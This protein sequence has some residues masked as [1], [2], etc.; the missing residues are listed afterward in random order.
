MLHN[1]SAL[2]SARGDVLF[3]INRKSSYKE[4]HLAII[5][6]ADDVLHNYLEVFTFACAVALICN[7]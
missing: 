3:T 2:Q 4:L 7:Q 5:K 6:K 1:A